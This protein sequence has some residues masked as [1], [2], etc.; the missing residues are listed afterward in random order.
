MIIKTLTPIKLT[1]HH[2]KNIPVAITGI[3]LGFIT[4]GNLWGGLGAFWL[5][6]F[7]NLFAATAVI[8]MLIKICLHPQKSYEEIQHPMIG[9]FYPTI[10]MTLMVFSNFVAT[11]IGITAGRCVWWL[12]IGIFIILA[13]LFLIAQLKNFS[14]HNV[15]PSWFV[16]LVGIGAAAVSSG[17]VR[18]SQFARIFFY[19]AFIAYLCALLGFIYRLATHGSI[20]ENKKLTLAIIA[21]PAS[22]CLA[23]YMT[24][25]NIPS[26]IILAILVPLA[27]ASTFYV[28]TLIPKFLSIPF[29]PGFAPLT[30]PLAVGSVAIQRIANYQSSINTISAT[31]F[32]QLFYIE[33]FVATLVIGYIVYKLLALLFQVLFSPNKNLFS[34]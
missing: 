9:S 25:T 31:Y 17:P 19:V 7:A 33:L 5:Q 23:G 16:P 24:T 20:P 12:G 14:W 26:A 28:Y 10:G 2:F 4:L 22:V 34:H 27:I 11:S 13:T 6:D 29:H 32:Y 15:L 18:M 8:L 1:C 21:A 30:F 3:S